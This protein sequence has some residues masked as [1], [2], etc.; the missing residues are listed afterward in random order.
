MLEEGD[1]WRIPEITPDGIRKET[2]KGTTEGNYYL[3]GFLLDI[4][5]SQLKLLED[6]SFSKRNNWWIFRKQIL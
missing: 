5:C 1:L 2:F 3:W 6:Y 4:I